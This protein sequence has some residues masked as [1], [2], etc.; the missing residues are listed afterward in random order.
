[1]EELLALM[2]IPALIIFFIFLFIVLGLAIFAF[3]LW[4]LIDCLVRKDWKGSEQVAWV[5]VLVFLNLLGAIIYFFAVKA[6]KR[7][8]R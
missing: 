4:M 7:K 6:A 5:L 1:M 3:W 2:A 8:K